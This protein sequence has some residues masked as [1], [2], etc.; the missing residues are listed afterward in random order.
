MKKDAKISWRY[1]NTP[2]EDTK[3]KCSAAPNSFLEEF[4]KELGG[5]HSA[6]MDVVADSI[7]ALVRFNDDCEMRK[8]TCSPFPS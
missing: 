1:C 6:L 3:A 4:K 5:Y 2:W 7:D 8:S